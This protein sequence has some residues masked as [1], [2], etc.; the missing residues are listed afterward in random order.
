MQTN[1]SRKR[2]PVMPCRFTAN[3][4]FHLSRV[5]SGLSDPFFK[6]CV[7]IQVIAE[8]KCFFRNLNSSPVTRSRVMPLASDIHPHD[9]SCFC[10]LP[11][12]AILSIIHLEPPVRFGY[13]HLC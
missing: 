5:F 7:S 3:E 11:Y 10:H 4:H 8:P 1:V 2:I 6:S 9:S 13:F 12:L